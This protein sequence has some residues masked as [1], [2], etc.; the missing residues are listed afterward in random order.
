M[1]RR[2]HPYDP[3]A[4]RSLVAALLCRPAGVPQVTPIVGPADFYDPTLSHVYAAIVGLSL[5]GAPIDN[6]T[7]AA[8]LNGHGESVD[9]E[10]LVVEAPDIS[11]PGAYA[12][13]V[14][15]HAR[16]RRA[17][18]AALELDA[19]LQDVGQDL[20]PLLARHLER[21]EAIGRAAT[22][23]SSWLPLDLTD[24]LLGGESEAPSLLLRADGRALLYP[25]R[26]HAFNG[27]SE[28][29]KSW[30]ALVAVAQALAAGQAAVYVD[31]EDNEYGIVGRLLALSVPASAILDRFHYIRPAEP[32]SAAGARL[33]DLLQ[34][35]RPTIAIVDGVTEAMALH[36]LDLK[37]NLDYARFHAAVPKRLTQA[38]AAVASIDHVTKDKETRGRFALGAQHKLAAID[39]AAYTIDA[40]TPFGKERTGT[41]RITVAKDRPG[42]VREHSAGGR[43][44][45]LLTLASFPDGGVRSYLDPVPEHDPDKPFEP[46]K[47]MERISRLVE[48]EPGLSQR[49]IRASVKGNHEAKAHALELLVARGYLELEKGPR[50]S[51]LYRSERPYREP[52]T[53]AIYDDSD[54]DE[55]F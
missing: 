40:L 33:D 11:N 37:D 10:A 31:F 20:S 52:D 34:T 48:G 23:R 47:L 13:I 17:Q 30:L 5:A 24:A 49:G 44:A 12:L 28:S 26:T 14:A 29:L 4:E 55:E 35:A 46:T 43:I 9:L 3:A 18:G 27:E 50:R 25:G 16:R 15:D 38:G 51:Q 6:I 54:D 53:K 45:G 39:G 22:A 8:T 32:I 1:T 41:A 21:I 36:G 2:R 7:V 19:A 42:G